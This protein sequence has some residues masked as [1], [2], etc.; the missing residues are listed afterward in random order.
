MDLA[1][2]IGLILGWGGLALGV[3]LEGK[4][5]PKGFAGGFSAYFNPAALVI[6][7]FGTFGATI[8]SFSLKQSK[9][10]LRIT[11]QAFKSKAIDAGSVISTLVS[12]AEKARREGLLVL[13][14]DAAKLQDPF[15][16]KGIQLVVDG[17]DMELVR[18]ILETELAFL[19]ERHKIG[20][21]IFMSL[22]GFAPT[23]GIIGTVMGLVHV[24]G[25]GIENT[26]KLAAGIAVAFLA[27]FYGI[28]FANLIFLP[29]ANKLKMNSAAEILLREVMI[30][31]ILS[32]QAGDNPRIVEEKLKAFLPPALRET[33]KGKGARRGEISAGVEGRVPA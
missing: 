4:F 9:D 29:I 16:K 8:I 12:F 11:L 33:V 14:D 32:I 22:G 27:T 13:E 25:A 26:E 15:L 2:I 24:I 21:G 10:F 20:E 28:S 18:N 5:A 30:E 7:I 1:T 23:L 3:I 31:G 19:E 17:T 6:I